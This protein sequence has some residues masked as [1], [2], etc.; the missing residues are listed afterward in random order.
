MP[1]GPSYDDNSWAEWV[2]R[3]M[4]GGRD[5][6][7]RAFYNDTRAGLLNPATAPEQG[8][9]LGGLGLGLAD[10]RALDMGE[11]QRVAD[12]VRRLQIVKALMGGQ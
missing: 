9:T 10:R 5:M 4:S 8:S 1:N 6:G 7:Q 11:A 12:Q 2:A 3:L